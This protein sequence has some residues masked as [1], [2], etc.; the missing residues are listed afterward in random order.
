MKD[1]KNPALKH[2]GLREFALPVIV[3]LALAAILVFA[4]TGV[5][6]VSDMQ[7]VELTRQAAIRTAVECYS[8]EGA[9]PT[10]VKYMEDNY[11]LTYDHS[12]YVIFYDAFS[13]NIMP[14]IEVY[15]K[16]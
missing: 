8:I 2:A 12:K 14:Q 9:Y 4:V 3:T 1:L 15:E 6:H 16:R 7:G 13:S 11:G 10:D 5:G